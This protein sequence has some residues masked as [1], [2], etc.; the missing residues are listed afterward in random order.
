MSTFSLRDRKLILSSADD[1]HSHTHSV[2]LANITTFCIDG[3]SIGVEAG[4]VLRELLNSMP[5]LKSAN[6]SN[7]FSRRQK[8]EIP[9]TLAAICHGLKSRSTLCD[10]DLS[11]NAIGV[12]AVE[13]IVPFL[14]GNRSLRVLKI[15]NVGFGPAAGTIAAKAL[16]LS[17]LINSMHQRPSNLRAIICGRS[18]LQD[19]SA[20]AW[21]EA[22]ASYPNLVAVHIPQNGIK[23]LGL[24]A[25]AH[26]LRNCRSLR[27]I[28]VADNTSREEG[29]DTT[30][31]DPDV[32]ATTAFANGLS[33]WKELEY[34]N[35]SDCCLTKAGTTQII[36][37]L[38]L[39]NN[40]KLNALLLENAYFDESFGASLLQALRAGH[41]PSLA[42]LKIS[43]HEGL[44]DVETG[45]WSEIN[46]IL[47]GRQGG[48]VSERD[49]DDDDDTRYLDDLVSALI[50]APE[51]DSLA[52]AIAGLSV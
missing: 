12:L 2:D 4:L 40:V 18:R 37:A 42:V 1:I 43:E 47:R 17:A 30:R 11:D 20:A 45:V 28:N 41:L 27:Y 9:E 21:S 25:I 48:V 22:F 32:D 44:E 14:L 35:L 10:L 36:A 50:D 3:N 5:I 39:G 49:I 33:S 24:T 23:E 6:F 13:S 46:T 7:I 16:H 19:E 29:L 31:T 51:S 8:E 26:G 52:D 15:N 34:L 38:A